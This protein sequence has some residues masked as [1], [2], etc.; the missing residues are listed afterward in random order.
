M[1]NEK[2]IEEKI[3]SGEI[4]PAEVPFSV[5]GQAKEMSH[6]LQT[7]LD[8]HNKNNFLVVDFNRITKEYEELKARVKRTQKMLEN[9]RNYSMI[10][11]PIQEGILA[12]LRQLLGR[13]EVNEVKTRTDRLEAELEKAHELIENL[14]EEW[15]HPSKV[16][17]LAQDFLERYRKEWGRINNL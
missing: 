17:E 7:I 12:A 3:K 15:N 11:T 5:Y 1:I 14:A 16:M 6:A 13:G 2:E 10:Y 9:V 8:N 4:K